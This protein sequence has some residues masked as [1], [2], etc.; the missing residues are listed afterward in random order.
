MVVVPAFPSGTWASLMLICGAAGGV[1]VECADTGG[2][3]V[4]GGLAEERLPLAGARGVARRALEEL[5]VVA[6][7][8][9]AAQRA[10]DG[11]RAGAE[12]RGCDHREVLQVVEQAGV[13]V[14]CVVRCDAII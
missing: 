11:D 10:A 13:A 14:A 5:H 4:D 12:L 6:A 1:D 7:R 8:G 3:R 9:H 2:A